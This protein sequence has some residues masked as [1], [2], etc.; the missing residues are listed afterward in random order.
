MFQVKNDRLRVDSV[1]VA[2][3][4][5]RLQEICAR[6]YGQP[7]HGKPV[8]ADGKDIPGHIISER[9]CYRNLCAG[10]GKKLAVCGLNVCGCGDATK[11]IFPS[12]RNI[13]FR[14]AG[15][16][17]AHKVVIVIYLFE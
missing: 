11:E 8:A 10:M 7:Y 9:S 2:F 12:S 4:V 5:C 14:M 15:G 6:L 17:G 1:L 16:P 3:T 13:F